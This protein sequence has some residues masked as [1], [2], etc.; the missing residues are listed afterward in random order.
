MATANSY[1]LGSLALLI[2]RFAL[3]E[4]LVKISHLHDVP[5]IIAIQ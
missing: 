5:L 4:T 1:T 2:C 3:A